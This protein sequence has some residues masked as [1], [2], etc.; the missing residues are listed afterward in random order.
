MSPYLAAFVALTVALA[1]FYGVAVSAPVGYPE[2]SLYGN[3]LVKEVVFESSDLRSSCYVAGWLVLANPTDADLVAEVKYPIEWEAFLEGRRVGWSQ[4]SSE[5]AM[6]TIPAH[7]EYRERFSFQAL[8]PGYYEVEWGGMRRGVD[9]GAGELVPRLVTEKVVYRQ[10]E[11]GYMTF[12]YYNP[13]PYTV[14]FSPPSKVE[15]DVFVDGVELDRGYFA[16]ISWIGT[17]FTVEPGATFK[18]MDFY[19]TVPEAGYVTYS[20]MGASATLRVLPETR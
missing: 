15:I 16:F 5:W 7:V 13:R 11:D 6:I 3:G 17:S 9:V 4:Q 14:T 10:Y 2:D 20:G 12:E 19:F 8:G 1:G 18:V